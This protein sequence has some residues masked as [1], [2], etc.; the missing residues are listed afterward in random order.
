MCGAVGAL[1]TPHQHR[2]HS[3]K[4]V[5]MFFQP[6]PVLSSDPRCCSPYHKWICRVY[7]MVTVL[8]H[9]ARNLAL[10]LIYYSPAHGIDF[11]N[12]KCIACAGEAHCRN[13]LGRDWHFRHEHEMDRHKMGFPL[14]TDRFT[15]YDLRWF[16]SITDMG[17]EKLYNGCHTSEWRLDFI[18][19]MLMLLGWT[20]GVS[21]V[22]SRSTLTRSW[23]VC[24]VL[25]RALDRIM[26]RETSELAKATAMNAALTAM[27]L[28]AVYRAVFHDP[29]IY[30]EDW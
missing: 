5:N 7:R 13:T 11:S 1:V 16:E 17:E 8:P 30:P 6:E 21:V 2:G 29:E 22:M 20:A 28:L 19:T 4:M 15:V 23:P 14:P 26:A 25:M 10:D 18:T 12:G 24:G 9:R 27:G 3:S